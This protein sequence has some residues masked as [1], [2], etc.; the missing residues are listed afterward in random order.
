MT[1]GVGHRQSMR[2][3]DRVRET[4]KGSMK[5]SRLRVIKKRRKYT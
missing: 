4:E 3:R 2:E 1:E 5:W